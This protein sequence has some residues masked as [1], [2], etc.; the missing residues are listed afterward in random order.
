MMTGYH[1]GSVVAFSSKIAI[2]QS[3]DEAGM[4]PGKSGVIV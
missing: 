1:D 2:E 3:G 4:S